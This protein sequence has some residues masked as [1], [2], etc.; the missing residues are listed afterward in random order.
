V[1]TTAFS[2]Q[3][4]VLPG[5]LGATKMGSSAMAALTMPFRQPRCYCLG[6]LFKQHVVLTI[7]WFSRQMEAF[8][9]VGDAQR[10]S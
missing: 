8:G 1:E 6:G 5:L 3:A 7:P 4:L 10:V 2:Q 9:P